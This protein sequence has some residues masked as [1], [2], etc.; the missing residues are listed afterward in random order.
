MRH[1]DVGAL[2]TSLSFAK[3]ANLGFFWNILFRPLFCPEPTRNFI[4]CI[5][6]FP[7]AVYTLLQIFI[8]WSF[9]CN[10][11]SETSWCGSSFTI[12][13]YSILSVTNYHRQSVKISYGQCELGTIFKRRFWHF[14]TTRI[15]HS[16]QTC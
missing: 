11:R 3:K 1:F 6:E 5:K 16:L 10:V 13:S 14:V 15:H 2:G 8:E 12:C 4:C 7:L 9:L